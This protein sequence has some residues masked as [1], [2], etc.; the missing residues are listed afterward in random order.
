MLADT[1]STFSIP[2]CIYSLMG[3]MIARIQLEHAHP[4][5]FNWLNWLQFMVD[6]LRIV[7]LWPLVLFIDKSK[8][9]LENSKGLEES[10][11]VQELAPATLQENLD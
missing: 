1:V 8:I 10:N 2:L 7:L 11:S 5:Q 3:I 4:K 6:V 9:W